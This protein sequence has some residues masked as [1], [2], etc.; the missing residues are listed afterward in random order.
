MSRTERQEPSLG[1]IRLGDADTSGERESQEETI[2]RFAQYH[3]YT[4]LGTIVDTGT[5]RG[6]E[7]PGLRKLRDMVKDGAVRRVLLWKCSH[8]SEDIK[9]VLSLLA[10]AGREPG[11]TFR[12]IT[13]QIDTS[14][15]ST[16]NLA[17][18]LLDIVVRQNQEATQS[19]ARGRRAR[20][21]Q[22]A[23]AAGAVPLGYRRGING[24]LVIEPTGAAL[25]RRIYE[26]RA[27][28]QSLRA[29]AGKLN[30]EGVPTP[31]RGRWHPGTLRHILRN[32]KYRGEMSFRSGQEIVKQHSHSPIICDHRYD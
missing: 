16:R 18:S 3:N 1:Y 14:N 24:D 32:R 20:A 27:A 12:S 7:L 21:Q 13:E 10:S 4:H 30:E 22:G 26:M 8:I 5:A 31:R 9:A 28:G 6:E 25:V 2:L 23:L 11:V 17:L 15:L 19:R 29:I